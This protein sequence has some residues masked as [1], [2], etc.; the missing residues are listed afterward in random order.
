MIGVWGLGFGVYGFQRDQIARAFSK[1][2]GVGSSRDCALI[3]CIP[4]TAA[5]NTGSSR[6]QK[7]TWAAAVRKSKHQQQP[8]AKTGEWRLLLVD[9]GG[10]REGGGGGTGSSACVQKEGGAFDFCG[11]FE[12]NQGGA[13]GRA[14]RGSYATWP[15]DGATFAERLPK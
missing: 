6:Q 14:S 7:Q 11:A 10:E 15:D 2:A 8:P 1:P 12:Y 9:G 3:Y 5:A 13:A 4:V